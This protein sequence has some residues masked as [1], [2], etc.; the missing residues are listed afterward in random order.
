ML[1]RRSIRMRIIVLVLVPVVALM[2]LYAVA[3]SLTLSSFLSLKAA[4]DIRNEVTNPITNVQL[5]LSAERALALQYLANPSRPKLNILLSQEPRT[6]AAVSGYL[7]AAARTNPSAGLAE[8]EA[9]QRWAEQLATLRVL[10]Q[11]V[12]NIGLSRASAA[13]S[14]STLIA[15]AD[16]VLTQAV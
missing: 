6:D 15:G 5:Q 9:S 4:D 11:T 2:G 7:N 16:F 10:R 3:L 1:R 8:R 12:V 13:V 14:Y